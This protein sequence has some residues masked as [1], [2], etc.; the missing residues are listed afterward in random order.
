ML[1]RLKPILAFFFFFVTENVTAYKSK[2]EA[3]MSFLP[4]EILFCWKKSRNVCMSQ[5]L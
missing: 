3:V 5:A 2:F 4:F 1:I